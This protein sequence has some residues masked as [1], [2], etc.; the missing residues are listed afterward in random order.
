MVGPGHWFNMPDRF[1][2]I[3]FAWIDKETLVAGL[4]NISKCLH[5]CIKK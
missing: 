3:G 1:M 2:R 4:E 5:D